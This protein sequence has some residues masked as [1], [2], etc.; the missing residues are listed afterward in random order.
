MAKEDLVS[1]EIGKD[2]V[3][4]IVD[5]HIKAAILEALGGK[6][7]MIEKVVKQILHQKVNSEGNVSRSDY[8]NKYSWLDFTVTKQ[9]EK[10]VRDELSNVVSQA[11]LKIKNALIARLKTDKGAM[12]VADALLEGLSGTFK[13]TWT[14]KVDIK[15]EPYKGS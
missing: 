11:T 4:P 13:N 1:L 10:A 9:I 14:S 8:D 3:T 2:V 7:E 5:K 15:I 12:L 6:D